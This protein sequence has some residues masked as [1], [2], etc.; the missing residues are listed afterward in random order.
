MDRV[1][2]RQALALALLVLGAFLL[3]AAVMFDPFV[4]ALAAVGTGLFW[5]VSSVDVDRFVSRR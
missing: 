2:L 3:W 1:G 5:T 4:T